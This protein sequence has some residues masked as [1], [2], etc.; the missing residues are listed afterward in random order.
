[1]SEKPASLLLLTLLFA[2]PLAA[3]NADLTLR[4]TPD[5]RY[6]AGEIGTVTAT[7]TNLGPDAASAAGVQLPKSIQQTLGASNFGCRELVASVLCTIPTLA[8]GQSHDFLVPFVPP[9]T[10]GTFVINGQTA[11]STA[12][13]NHDND[14]ASVTASAVSIADVA[15]TLLHDY[16]LT[17]GKSSRVTLLINNKSA[18]R[19]ES[20]TALVTFPEPLVA[21]Q[22]FP[23]CSDVEGAPGSFRCTFLDFGPGGAA[24]ALFDVLPG[25]PAPSVTMTASLDSSE[26]DWNP[27]DN[28]VTLTEPV[29]DIHDL[30]IRITPPPDS[31]DANNRVTAEFLFGNVSDSPAPEV[32]AEIIT[33]PADADP[34]AAGNG[35]TCKPSTTYRLLCTNHL[36][37]PH[38][39][40]GLRLPVQFP[41]H[42]IR[43]SFSTNVTQK[44][45]PEFTMQT[46]SV[47]LD[48]VFYRP[49]RVTSAADSGPGSLRQAIL[50]ANAACSADDTKTPCSIRFE[51]PPP[52]PAEGWFM[53][54]PRT[55]L[56]S[57]T[58]TDLL[59]DGEA[60]TALTGNTNPLGPE[61]F[62]L[63]SQAGDGAEGV[64]LLSSAAAVRGLAIGGFAGNGI[65]SVTRHILFI[66]DHHI[67]ERNYL[68]TDPTGA[69]AVPNGL[70]G[71]TGDGFRGE[72]TG[73]VISGNRRSGVFLTNNSGATMRDNRIGV[74][75]ATDD[76]LGNGASGV[77][78]SQD[79][80]SLLEHNVIAYSGDF[81]IAVARFS[82]AQILENRIIHNVQPGIDLGLD[83]PTLDAAPRIT[84]AR[85]DPSTGETVVEGITQAKLLT[86]YP[87]T[88]TAYVYANTRDEAGGDIFLGSALADPT[89]KFI[90]RYH[91][92]LTGKYIDAMYFQ[93]TNFG[94]GIGEQS[95]EFGPRTRM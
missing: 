29:Y 48:A 65:R 92:D 2:L 35:W 72:I 84:S 90:L 95:S 47:F 82:A 8:A 53:I 20:V 63:G 52:V 13:P 91:G 83:G 14:T 67:I 31:L 43:G 49:F 46:Q 71:L 54:A 77:Y 22:P 66:E 87:S 60:Q 6:N 27:A 50:D 93:L 74:A 58:V 59:V 86:P 34:S 70:R 42:E 25:R 17:T 10:A 26:A 4:L 51:I 79:S 11:S 40:S 16:S 44:P 23:Q 9:D 56:P 32:T 85:F 78:M 1:M 24:S 5:T 61:I 64:N 94:D 30:D 81:G 80:G 21:T 3:Q 62:L 45:A 37:A 76:P 7:V 15:V 12:D 75:A 69:T 39:V 18:R 33:F 88:V 68:G 73:N 28:R 36:I 89:G 55:P 57:I 41:A 38:S 19:P